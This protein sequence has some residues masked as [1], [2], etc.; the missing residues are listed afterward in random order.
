[1]RLIILNDL[2]RKRKDYKDGTIEEEYPPVLTILDEAHIY[3]PKDINIKAPLRKTLIDISREGRKYGM[4][5]IC[6]TQRISELNNT[7]LSQMSTKIIL[8]TSQEADKLIIQ[9]ECGLSDVEN[10]KL[11]L[12]DSGN[13][14]I[15]SPIL[16]NKTAIAFQARCNYSK[17]KIT[18]NAFDE[19][20]TLETSKRMDKLEV[21]LIE[22]LPLR[23]AEFPKVLNDFK[24]LNNEKTPRTIKEAKDILQIL[25]NEGKVKYENSVYDIT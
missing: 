20:K 19:L 17:P 23:M 22:H 8:K 2:W 11:H 6:A 9:K 5:L 25:I 18:I 12:L 13:G 4:F 3:A 21:Y 10:N 15:V 14:Y 7:V 1:L 24:K 16:K